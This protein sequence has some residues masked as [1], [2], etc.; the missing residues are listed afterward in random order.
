MFIILLRPAASDSRAPQLHAPPAHFVH[1]AREEAAA[2]GGAA[3]ALPSGPAAGV[4]GT[5]EDRQGRQ[6]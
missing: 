3:A 6:R 2:E 1:A 5:Q 4:A